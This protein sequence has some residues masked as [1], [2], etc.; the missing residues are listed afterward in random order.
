MSIDTK[1]YRIVV[2]TQTDPEI[3][4]S[5]LLDLIKEVENELPQTHPDPEDSGDFCSCAVPVSG[6]LKAGC[7]VCKKSIK[8]A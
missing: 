8:S 5:E 1:Y 2:E 3:L 4:K 7:L 6:V